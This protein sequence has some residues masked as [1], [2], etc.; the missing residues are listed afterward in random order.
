MQFPLQSHC[1]SSDCQYKWMRSLISSLSSSSSLLLVSI[2]IYCVMLVCAHFG[3][4]A[5][6]HPS[7]VYRNIIDRRIILHR[8]WDRDRTRQ[9]M[10]RERE[11]R[12]NELNFLCVNCVFVTVSFPI[13]REKKK[14]E[15]LYICLMLTFYRYFPCVCRIIRS[16]ACICALLFCLFFH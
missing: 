4:S 2:R 3:S 14:P 7:I 5:F 6:D 16:N 11:R 13:N 12:E 10:E 15:P 1:S 8:R 9:G